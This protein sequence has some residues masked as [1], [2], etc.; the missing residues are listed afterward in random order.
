RHFPP[1][2]DDGAG[3]PISSIIISRPTARESNRVM[4][5]SAQSVVHDKYNKPNDQLGQ[6]IHDIAKTHNNHHQCTSRS[7]G[8]QSKCMTIPITA[9]DPNS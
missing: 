5:S 6:F 9:N 3:E 8:G 4:L 2:Y 1:Q 7:T